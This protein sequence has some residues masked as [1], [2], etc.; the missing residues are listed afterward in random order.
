MITKN[1][2]QSVI[3]ESIHKESR[4]LQTLPQEKSQS[5]KSFKGK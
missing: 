5:K 3:R 2:Y 1:F 4:K